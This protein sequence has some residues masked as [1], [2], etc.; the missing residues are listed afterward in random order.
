MT[1]REGSIKNNSY[2]FQEC[3]RGIYLQLERERKK[4]LVKK[5]FS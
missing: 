1:W 5:I 3:E 2:I 4:N